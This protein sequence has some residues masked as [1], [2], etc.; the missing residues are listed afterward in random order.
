MLAASLS[1]KRGLTWMSTQR[2]WQ[3]P[4]QL[5]TSLWGSSST[6]TRSG[7]N[8]H[9][10]LCFFSLSGLSAAF[11][12]IPLYSTPS[13]AS[14]F[15]TLFFSS[16]KQGNNLDSAGLSFCKPHTF[17]VPSRVQRVL[18]YS[19]EAFPRSPF[20]SDSSLALSSSC[21]ST[22]TPLHHTAVTPCMSSWRILMS[23]L[24]SSPWLVG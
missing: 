4:N 9:D 6:H 15:L 10:K 22:R 16:S 24:Q 1:L 11:P 23:F 14:L 18:R 5:S 21:S 12:P 2:W 13:T 7:H 8:A 20:A 3:W 17:S 19:G